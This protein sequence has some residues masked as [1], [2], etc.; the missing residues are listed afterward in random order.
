MSF[1]PL[2]MFGVTGAATAKGGRRQY[3]RYFRLRQIGGWME[4]DATLPLDV[5]L[6]AMR[7]HWKAGRETE[8]VALAK[9]AA[10]YVHAKPTDGK[11]ERG[12]ACALGDDELNELL[13][14]SSAG[15][16]A[17]MEHQEEP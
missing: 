16:A 2:I 7:D 6:R 17:S 5:L 9:V 15:T 13:R 11:L 1:H 12:L 3:A 14:T 10:P 4:E 8:A